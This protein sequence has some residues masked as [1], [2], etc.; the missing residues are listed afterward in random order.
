MDLGGATESDGS[1]T[2]GFLCQGIRGGWPGVR[3]GQPGRARE[4][5]R[6]SAGTVSKWGGLA[7]EASPGDGGDVTAV[8]I[9]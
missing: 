7:G 1:R 9:G 2:V 8:G 5:G 6:R 3:R 4:E